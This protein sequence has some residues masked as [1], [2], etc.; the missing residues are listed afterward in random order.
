MP[1]A[2]SRPSPTP[3][4]LRRALWPILAAILPALIFA[5]AWRALTVRPP[6]TPTPTVRQI[7]GWLATGEPDVLVVGPSIARGDIDPAVLADGLGETRKVVTRVAQPQASAAIWYAILRER[8]YGAGHAPP[9][10]VLVGTIQTLLTVRPAD[11]KMGDLTQHF[12]EPDE[13]IRRKTLRSPWPASVQRALESRGSLRA[14]LLGWFKDAPVGVLFGSGPDDGAALVAAAGEAALGGTHGPQTGRAIPVVE[15]GTDENEL[16]GVQASPE[17]SYLPDL[18]ALVAAHGGRLAV[19]LPP[20]STRRHTGFFA[21]AATERA[22]VAEANRLGVAWV[23][24]RRWSTSDADF[25]DGLHM[26][27]EAAS[28][29]TTTAAAALMAANALGPGP[30]VPAAAPAPPATRERLGSLPEWGGA[31]A[32]AGPPPCGSSFSV[33]NLAVVSDDV[34]R[35]VAYNVMSPVLVREDDTRLLHVAPRGGTCSG[36]FALVGTTVS[37]TA[38]AEKASPPRLSFDDASSWVPPGTTLRWTFSDGWSDPTDPSVTI[39]LVT[40]GDGA[41][42]TLQVNDAEVTL[43]GAGARRSATVAIPGNAPPRAVAVAAPAGRWV[44]VHTLRVEAGGS[45]A[46]LVEPPATGRDDLVAAPVFA[47]APPPALE[48]GSLTGGPSARRLPAPWPDHSGCSPVQV[49]ED[50]ALLN[51]RPPYGAWVPVSPADGSDPYKNGRT[52]TLAL[53]EDRRC[54]SSNVRF[55]YLRVWMYPGDTFTEEVTLPLVGPPI[56]SLRAQAVATTAAVGTVH[57]VL[58]VAGETRSEATLPV[59]DLAAEREL[60]LTSPILPNERKLVTV[61]ASISAEAAPILLSW[62][63]VED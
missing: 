63:A 46:V 10:V 2:P 54:R 61:E 31:V 45:A 38:T 15:A 27:A 24:L 33:P 53:R 23:D 48:T 60:A 26:H 62:F 9:L 52:Y 51:A 58:R 35:R 57:L 13:V 47:A 44:Y 14:P 55:P 29:F 7:D 17:E 25:T 5:V 37:A 43:T 50:G 4:G 32:E 34:L 39:E 42:P 40:L 49:L 3:T 8:V 12:A 11:A 56:R 28:R 30:V 22:A 36:R 16:D 59:A 19:V 1:P 20:S 41:E 18:A 21:D 6:W